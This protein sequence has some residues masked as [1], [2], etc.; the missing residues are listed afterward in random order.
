MGLRHRVFLQ[1]SAPRA[2]VPD[3]V[4]DML[5]GKGL[6]LT[7]Q[8]R[9][10][11]YLVTAL[12]H[13]GCSWV[14]FVLNDRFELVEHDIESEID[15]DLY[16]TGTNQV[17]DAYYVNDV[18]TYSEHT[19]RVLVVNATAEQADYLHATSA[20]LFLHGHGVDQPHIVIDGD[21]V[22]RV[23]DLRKEPFETIIGDYAALGFWPT[24]CLFGMTPD[25]SPLKAANVGRFVMATV[26]P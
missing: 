14:C 18:A 22:V 9:N 6:I 16:E 7:E 3:E 11:L 26:C 8:P 23:I 13:Y 15:D 24:D 17:L 1:P 25:V 21:Q 20:R 2:H 12:R 10:P 5:T 19:I 4:S